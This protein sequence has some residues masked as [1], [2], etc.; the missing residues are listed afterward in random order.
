MIGRIRERNPDVEIYIQ[1]GFPP[2]QEVGG[3]TRGNAENY[4]EALKEVCEDYACVY[5]DVLE[6][7][8]DANG[9]LK[10]GLARDY[11]HL[12]NKGAEIWVENLHNPAF[13]WLPEKSD[14]AFGEAY[15][16][17]GNT[18]EEENPD[19]L[20]IA[21]EGPDAEA[22]NNETETVRPEG[23]Q[24]EIKIEEWQDEG[25]SEAVRIEDGWFDDSLFLGDSFTGGLYNYTLVFGG[26][27]AAQI[28][29]VNGLS[30]HHIVVQNQQL[31]YGGRMTSIENVVAQSGAK[32]L[33]LMIGMNDLGNPEEDMRSWWDTIIGNILNAA[34][35]V[36]VYLQSVTPPRSN[37]G[38]FT[39]DNVNLYNR[40]LRE[41]CEDY[42]FTYVDIQKGI[43]GSD[44]FMKLEFMANNEHFNNQGT[45]IW[46][47][48]LHRPESYHS[49]SEEEESA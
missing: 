22:T 3:V 1:S 47:E 26:L 17:A 2:S 35:D 31:L 42:G 9:F 13:Y 38:R 18:K 4:N 48:N 11:A 27:G 21:E 14:E 25:V 36:D 32:K 10:S 44:G 5:V 43:A 33:F 8:V 41:V 49:Y 46:L 24:E 37:I 15:G 19:D 30:C 29:Y 23:T 12:N 34:P 6:G 28:C 45:E 20:L 40:I 39:L 7:L 16:G